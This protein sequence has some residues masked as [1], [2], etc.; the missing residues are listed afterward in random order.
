MYVL[1]ALLLCC[2]GGYLA[3]KKGYVTDILKSVYIPSSLTRLNKYLY[4]LSYVH[5]GIDY[6]VLIPLKKGPRKIV[7]I[8]D[9]DQ[10]DV[11]D[12][13]KPYLGPNEDFHGIEITPGHLEYDTLTFHT[14]YGNV[15]NFNSDDTIFLKNI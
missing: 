10:E 4:Q 9:G 12:Q 1:Y 13:V 15:Y 3:Y 5:Q 8:T 2:G 6:H 7:R 11:T 14:R